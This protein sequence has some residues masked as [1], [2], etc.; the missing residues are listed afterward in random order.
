MQQ[1]GQFAAR[2]RLYAALDARLHATTRFFGAAALTNAALVELCAVPWV[3]RALYGCAIDYFDVIGCRLESINR[4]LARL[5]EGGH[6][7]GQN[8]DHSLVMF[9]QMEVER[10]LCQ[11]HLRCH[12]HHRALEQI[13]RL[14]HLGQRWSSG[15]R[16]SPS[17][18]ILG[19]VLGQCQIRL[20][21][22]MDFAVLSDRFNIGC[23]LTALLQARK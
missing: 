9:E 20:G 2:A 22:P 23:A 11:R 5:I 14:L 16:Y 1:T 21:R 12:L 7:M 15:L 8:L 10:I 3:G 6:I 4:V 19:Q 17:I 18:R 13:N